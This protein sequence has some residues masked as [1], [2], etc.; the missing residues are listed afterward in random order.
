M[1]N[2]ENE[3]LRAQL[4]ERDKEIERLDG[5]QIVGGIARHHQLM[6]ELSQAKETINDFRLALK[7]IAYFEGNPNTPNI[8]V[9]RNYAIKAYRNNIHVAKKALSKH[10]DSTEVKDGKN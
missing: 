10:P 8:D 4:A 1:L 9:S 3:Q 5:E 6:R 7:D 2:Q